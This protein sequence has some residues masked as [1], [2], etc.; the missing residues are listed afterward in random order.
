MRIPGVRGRWI[1][2]AVCVLLVLVGGG[3]ITRLA[4]KDGPAPADLGVGIG[5]SAAPTTPPPSPPVPVL[6]TGSPAAALSAAGVGRALAGPLGDDR[7]G[8]RVSAMVLDVT[9]GSVLLDRA[10]GTYAVPASTA[11][12]ATAAALLSVAEPDARLTTTVVAGS[13]PGE[14]VLV[15][16][17]DATLSA[18]P[19]GKP[20]VYPGATRIADLAALARRGGASKVTR[21][22]V[23]GTL[24][25][26]PA[27]GPGWDPLD[28]AGGYITPITAAMLDGGRVGAARA[29]STTPDLDA[30]RAL[31]V[32]LGAPTAQVVRGKAAPGAKRLG[33]VSSPPIARLVEQT[34]LTSDNVLAEALARQVALETGAPASFA[35][36]A[37]AVRA[38]LGRLGLPSTGDRLV[39]GS[40]MSM[41]NSITPALLAAILRTAAGSTHPELHTLVPALPVSGYDGTLDDRFREGGSVRGA[42]EVRAKTGTLTGISSL[43]GLVR[44]QDGR[45]LAFAV[46]ADRVPPTG[47]LAAEDALDTIATTLVTCTC[48]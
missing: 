10:S 1:L 26:G 28:I 35:G 34:L 2:I 47:T 6:G 21:V 46:L 24:F 13:K 18:A 33:Q 42:G 9:S 36:A 17:G 32:A 20:T 12:L 19:R 25:S 4:S 7:L 40:G 41:R 5:E 11:K 3:S 44:G 8:G 14:V 27:L 22:V 30:G 39:D 45:L 23:D 29:R 16:G 48:R 15:G 43:A 31:A 37:A 38:T